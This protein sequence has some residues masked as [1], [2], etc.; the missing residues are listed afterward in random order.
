[1]VLVSLLYTAQLRARHRNEE[2]LEHALLHTITIP[3]QQLQWAIPGKEAWIGA[4]L[5]DVKSI[6]RTADGNYK[7]TGLFDHEESMVVHHVKNQERKEA[8]QNSRLLD[9]LFKML[10][11]TLRPVGLY[12]HTPATTATP[13]NGLYTHT[14]SREIK[15][16]TSPP[17][18]A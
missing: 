3:A 17:P 18:E 6:T 7:L 16:C 15:E 5:F 12:T 13:E 1:M 4:E 8:E 2:R 14:L 10:G 9:K 11:A